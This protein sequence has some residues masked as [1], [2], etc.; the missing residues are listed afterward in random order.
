MGSSTQNTVKRDDKMYSVTFKRN[1]YSQREQAIIVETSDELKMLVE[2]NNLKCTDDEFNRMLYS[3]PAVFLSDRYGCNISG[4][5]M[6]THKNLKD[7]YYSVSGNHEVGP[8][9]IEV[10]GEDDGC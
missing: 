5:Y 10:G 4:A 7:S 8:L 2:R 1:S 6:T 9:W 3:L